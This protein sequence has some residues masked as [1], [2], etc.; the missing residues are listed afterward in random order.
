MFFF[1]F[2]NFSKKF[3]LFSTPEVTSITSSALEL[4]T[5]T[6]LIEQPLK[7]FFRHLV[8]PRLRGGLESYLQH[9]PPP[10]PKQKRSK[11]VKQSSKNDLS[12]ELNN[13][14]SVKHSSTEKQQVSVF[15]LKANKITREGKDSSFDL[16]S[17]KSSL[18]EI[19]SNPIHTS[20]NKSP[21]KSFSVPKKQ[22]SDQALALNKDAEKS[23]RMLFFDVFIL[24]FYFL[25]LF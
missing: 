17:P 19:R 8:N 23:N 21:R 18:S 22:A 14:S 13:P 2:D 24:V 25:Y 12:I 1:R 9:S 10:R 3:Q 11:I 15:D 7:N 5:N 16:F 4:K 6:N 20:S